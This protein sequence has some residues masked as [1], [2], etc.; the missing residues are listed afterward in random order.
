VSVLPAVNPMQL[1]GKRVLVTGASSGIGRDTAVLLSQLGASVLA[2]GRDAARL[3]ETRAMLAGE[4]HGIEAFDLL[5][6][7]GIPAW[8]QQAAAR[9]GTLD[10]VVHCAGIHSTMGVRFQAVA[11]AELMMKANWASAWAIA[12]GLRQKPVRGPEVALVF[13]SS[14]MALVGQ[15][16]LTAYASS[17]GAVVALTRALAMELAAEK[18]R[19]NCVVPGHV[20]TEMAEKVGEYLS[21]EQMQEIARQ[22]PLGIGTARDVSH[23]IAFLVAET[24]RW[25]TGSSIVVDGGFTAH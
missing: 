4:G 19:V 8:M 6:T 10:A 5:D 9:F 20:K 24:G 25:L 21:P 18:I 14:I 15:P 22:H 23:A 11:D 2:C 16:G 1:T 17:K 7:E 13:V 12:K 3:E